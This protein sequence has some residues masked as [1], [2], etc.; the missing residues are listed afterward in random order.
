[1]LSVLILLISLN[2][3]RCCGSPHCG[4]P[5]SETDVVVHNVC[6]LNTQ[7][8]SH[9]TKS[10]QVRYLFQNPTNMCVSL[11]NKR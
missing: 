3:I 4:S 5:L 10:V 6:F 7:F 2:V 11:A 8:I 1:M 9:R